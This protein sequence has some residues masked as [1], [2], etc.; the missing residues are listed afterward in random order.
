MTSSSSIRWSIN[1]NPLR[2]CPRQDIRE[3]Q[4]RQDDALALVER[5]GVQGLRVDVDWAW[6]MPTPEAVSEAA[7]DWYRAFF[8]DAAARGLALYGVLY[9]PPRWAMA[10]AARQPERFVAAWEAFCRLLVARLPGALEVVQVWNEP[11]NYL[12]ALKGDAV[13]FH[14]PRFGAWQWPREVAWDL[15]V[16]MFRVARQT[17]PDTAAVACNPLVTLLPFWP[18]GASWLDW[19]AF[20]DQLLTRAGDA[21]DMVALDHYPDT[22]HP[23]TGPIEWACLDE[24]ARRVREPASAWYGKQIAIGELGY[25]S[26]PHAPRLGPWGFFPEGARGEARM[27]DWYAAALPHVAESLGAEGLS[28]PSATWVNVYELLDSRQPHGGTGL[29]ALEDHFGLVRADGTPK[30]AFE[31]VRAVTAGEPIASPSLCARA[32]PLYWQLGH[33]LAGRLP[34]ARDHWVLPA[35]PS[36]EAARS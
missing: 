28:Q 35:S 16:A 25:S 6:L 36:G 15:L 21:I 33:W 22:W 3:L 18:G 13:L 29:L 11:N 19:F 4:R 5:L 26:A 2:L 14:G 30:P 32:A 20:T 27:A 23:G 17:F 9:H 24:V 10:Q 31:V 8:Q 7:L 34:A 1:L 12:A